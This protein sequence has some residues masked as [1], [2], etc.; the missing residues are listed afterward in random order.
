MINFP[1]GLHYLAFA[2]YLPLICYPFVLKSLF[3][4]F[5]VL[6]VH[7][8]FCV[9]IWQ[10]SGKGH[11]SFWFL[12]SKLSRV[13]GSWL[14][15]IEWN[16][17]EQNGMPWSLLFGSYSLTNL[18][19]NLYF[20]IYDLWQGKGKKTRCM[21]TAHSRSVRIHSTILDRN[22]KA[23]SSVHKYN[24]LNAIN[25]SSTSKGAG[26]EVIFI[27]HDPVPQLLLKKEITDSS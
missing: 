2:Y 23:V 1:R 5:H 26:S 20:Q 22:L 8:F 6:R 9:S 18:L 14:L 15:V 25:T 16:G 7:N 17:I 10:P 13:P 19:V 24:F 12:Y 11:V 21:S 27:L 4:V 3:R